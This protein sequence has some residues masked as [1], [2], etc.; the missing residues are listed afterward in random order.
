MDTPARKSGVVVPHKVTGLK[1]LGMSILSVFA[2]LLMLSWRRRWIFKKQ[3]DPL[4]GPVIFA[5]WHNRLSVSVWSWNK[6]AQACWPST[7]MCAL[8]SASKDGALITDFVERFGV[9]V[10]RGSTS[11]RGPQALLEASGWLAKKYSITITPD[12]PR[13]PRYKA[14][15]GT[16]QLAMIT[17]AA[18]IPISYYIHS[19]ICLHSWDGFQIP[20]PFSR[21]DMHV[22]EP[23]FVPRDASVEEQACLL[24]KLER[25]LMELTRD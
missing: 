8:I 1:R 5:M 24:A 18:I 7:G 25:D 9:H 4:P 2:R 22:G 3:T 16:I 12:G 23:I 11:R 21:C 15:M 19:K 13:G 20:L 10:V 14:K 6:F 17:G